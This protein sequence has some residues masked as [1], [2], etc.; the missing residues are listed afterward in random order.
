MNYLQAK[1]NVLPA[2]TFYVGGAFG[3][4]AASSCRGLYPIRGTWAE[5]Q[6]ELSPMLSSGDASPSGT[7]ARDAL[8]PSPYPL[9][10][11]FGRDD[12]PQG[13]D[14]RIG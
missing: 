9:S 7:M 10:G 11:A 4:A 1:A 2:P 12:I 13:D 14:V 3:A 6:G 8:L 5:S